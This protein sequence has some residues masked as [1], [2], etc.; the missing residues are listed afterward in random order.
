MEK[1][2]VFVLM[3]EVYLKNQEGY[4][5]LGVFENRQDAVNELELEKKEFFSEYADEIAE[6]D[7]EI[8]ERDGY[9]QWFDESMG[10]NFELCVVEQ[11]LR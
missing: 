11:T 8:T 2:K 4:E 5:I 1:K 6:G 9:F 10:H 3:L 7:S